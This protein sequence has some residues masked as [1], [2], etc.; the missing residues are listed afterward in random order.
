MCVPVCVYVSEVVSIIPAKQHDDASPEYVEPGPLLAHQQPAAA[1]EGE[2]RQGLL[3]LRGGHLQKELIKRG[4]IG[5]R[6]EVR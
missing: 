2:T 6:E 3:S 5:R 4:S 1:A